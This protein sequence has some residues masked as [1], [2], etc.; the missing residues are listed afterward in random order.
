MSHDQPADFS[1]PR[2]KSV[3]TLAHIS[4]PHLPPPPVRWQEILN[5][6]ALS[7]VS[8]KRFRR[9]VHLAATCEALV[10]DIGQTGVD[11]ILVSGDLTNFGTPAE[12]ASAARW[13]RT[14]PAPAMVIP[15]NHDCMVKQP[16]TTGLAQWRPWAADTFPYVRIHDDVA[17]VGVN[18]GIPTPPFM[19]CGHVGARQRTRL[20]R[21]LERLGEKGLCRVVMIHHPPRRGLVPW[22]KSL[23]DSREVAHL[24]QRTGAEIVLHGHSHD[25]TLTRIPG[26]DIPLLGVASASLTSTTP[27][28]QACWNHLAIHRDG[29][30][31][32]INLSRHRVD[33]SVSERASWCRP[34]RM[35]S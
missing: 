32:R 18:S 12:F 25:A 21:L 1:S 30:G 11:G 4:D 10:S 35:G 19:A 17:V 5:K 26:T 22:R 6:R 13:L 3:V 20:E 15:G 7:L 27:Q 33:G 34:G 8:W 24:F 31:W 14:L 23:L 9:H 29:S 2:G 16:E 28:R